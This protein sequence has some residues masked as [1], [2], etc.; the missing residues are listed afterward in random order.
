MIY[1]GCNAGKVF[2]GKYKNGWDEKE[3]LGLNLSMLGQ[4]STLKPNEINVT[5]SA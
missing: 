2:K 1:H 3:I 5:Q 4:R